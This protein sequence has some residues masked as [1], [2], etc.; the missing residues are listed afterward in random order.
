VTHGIVS[1]TGRS[2]LGI[3]TFEDFIQ[4]DAAI[5]PGNSGGALINPNGELIGINTAIFSKSGGSQGIGFAIPMHLAQ[6]VMRQI[7]E[8]GT[9]RRGWFGIE[10]QP[11]TP[12]LAQGLGINVSTGVL[13]AGVL[14][15]GPAHRGGLEPG[16]VITHIAG[17]AVD[18]PSSALYV[19]AK[20][21]PG[22]PVGVDGQRQG[23]P[24]KLEIEAAQRPQRQ[25]R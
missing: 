14:R 13:V 4:T 15:G 20:Q 7:I 5:N 6:D 11:L 25:Q 2:Q 8:H 21:T 22:K 16:D 9:V 17:E 3:N 23:K 10:T 12:E 1:A 18:N 19:I 24:F